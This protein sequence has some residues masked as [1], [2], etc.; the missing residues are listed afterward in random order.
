M[1]KPSRA[2]C[3]VTAEQ[4]RRSRRLS[5]RKNGAPASERT[6]K[7]CTVLAVSETAS[8]T[9]GYRMLNTGRHHPEKVWSECCR[10]VLMGCRAT[11]DSSVEHIRDRQQGKRKS[12]RKQSSCLERSDGAFG[13]VCHIQ[14]PLKG[15][16]K[17]QRISFLHE[18]RITALTRYATHK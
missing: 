15:L 13:G 5:R 11:L 9:T 2:W 7:S 3:R 10:T 6:R 8:T 12:R 18:M 1:S 4:K 17:T 16:G 14:A